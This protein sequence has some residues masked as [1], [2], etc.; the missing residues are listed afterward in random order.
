MARGAEVIWYRRVL[1]AISMA[2]LLVAGLVMPTVAQPD[3][4]EEVV[5]TDQGPVRGVVHGDYRSFQGIPYAAAPVG[6]LRWRPPQPPQGWREPLDATAPRSQCAQLAAFGLPE[7]YTEDCLYLNVTTP[8]RSHSR[9]PVMVWIHGGGYIN[10]SG[11]VYG[12]RKLAVE[13]DVV[14][15]TINYRLGP[16]G[17]LALP[18]LTAEAPGIQ[19]GN[20]GIED[21]QA[22]LRWVQ[23]NAVAFGGDPG[24]VTIFGESAGSGSVCAH[25]VSPTAAGLFHRAIA[26]SYSCATRIA[27]RQDAEAAGATLAARFGCTDPHQAANCLRTKPVAEL[28]RAWPGGRPVVGGRELPLQ[29]P[30]A[31]R[32]DRF[33]HVP[34]MLGNTLDEMRLAVS[35]QYDATGH[36]VTPAQYEQ[37]VRST[38]GSN[39]DQVLQRYPLTNYPSPSIALATVQTDT[40][41]P[42]STCEHLTSYRAAS[43]GPVSVPVYA[44]QFVDRTAP[45]LVDAPNFDEGAE[46]GVELNFLFPNL[47]GRPLNA[48][49]QALAASM[50]KYWTNFAHAGNPNGGDL[51]RWP[52]F[53]SAAD[54]LALGLGPGGVRTADI[55][56]TSNCDFWESLPH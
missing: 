17:F 23:R 38:Y 48:Q 22:A 27:T 28:V 50:V 39:A 24:N 13:G 4:S 5:Y 34:L 42:L 18:A 32:S 53:R 16:L 47:F 8:R 49:Q 20:Y 12:P 54:V 31:L 26:Q 25:L 52:Q 56:K 45:P 46:H 9:L 30:D 43:A 1:L 33:H 7:S 2:A 37:I 40:G 14:V 51:P 21:Q 35:L 36:P 44:Y 10:G 6:D 19:S 55:A 11:A 41:T 3:T 15:V 29:P